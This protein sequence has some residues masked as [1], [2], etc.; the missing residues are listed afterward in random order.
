MDGLIAHNVPQAIHE[1][2]TVKADAIE[3]KRD[4]IYQMITKG[5]Y[6]IS[7]TCKKSYTKDVIDA[8]ITFLNN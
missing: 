1:L 7:N 2:R 6:N 3:M 5:E 4:L 8:L